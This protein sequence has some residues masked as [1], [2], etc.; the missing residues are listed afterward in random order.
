MGLGSAREFDLS[1]AREKARVARQKLQDG[2]D[3]IDARKAERVAK[4]KTITF[5]KAALSYFRAHQRKWRKANYRVQ[6]LSTLKAYAFPKIGALPVTAID[7][8][9][10]LEVIEPIKLA[11]RRIANSL[12]AQIGSV[13]EWAKIQG[14]RDGDNPAAAK[15]IENCL[16]SREH[17]REFS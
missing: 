10:V 12:C 1:E 16:P 6:F 13:L 5:E 11:K 17:L 2:I 4:A 7:V 9:L 8:S 15:Y 14:Y 3:P